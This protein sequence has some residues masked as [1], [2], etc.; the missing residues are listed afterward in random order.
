M[1]T[2][3]SI[4][5]LINKFKLS[6]LG[7]WT[8]LLTKFASVQLV[9]QALTSLGGI[10]LIRT[11]SKE[12]YAYLTIAST[13]QSTMAILVDMGV[14]ASL[15]AI[16]GKVWQ[17]QYRFGQL[18]NTA[19]Q[20]RY[21]LA[22][23]SVLVTVPILLGLLI[24]N[25]ASIYYALMLTGIVLLGLNY[26]I[27]NGVL[28]IVPKLHSLVNKIQNLELISAI[29]RFGFLGLACL[30]FVNAALTSLIT[31]I[32]GGIQYILWK[33]IASSKL[34]RTASIN[35]ED[36]RFILATM[37]SVA[38][39]SIFFCV[40]GQLT[41]FLISLFG[42]VENVAEVGALGRLAVI[43]TIINSTLATIVIPSFARCHSI[44]VLRRRY[45]QILGIFSL[46]GL[47]FVVAS[48]IYADQFLWILGSKY[49]HLRSELIIMAL[50]TSFNSLVGL[51][52]SIN[53]S[54]AWVK[55]MWVEIPTTLFFQISL[56]T[57]LDVS[58]V[59]GIVLFSL[60]SNIPL[61][62]VNAALTYQGF[63]KQEVAIQE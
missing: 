59:R 5:A 3:S 6:R 9:V 52:V 1:E 42:K 57:V 2:L 47:L 44:K 29:I 11:L 61:F 33:R 51:M 54:K 55:H 20:L 13:M 7:Y 19:I 46:L 24:Q 41:I 63:L 45:F 12:E 18:I 14:G 39:S 26:Q 34:D 22:L 32:I 62:L 38:P 36:K 30:T 21:R 4:T 49:S 31:S 15:F 40:Q 35:E 50:A 53:H 48:G 60:F 17:D 27:A 8:T 37:R 10:L 43:F 28:M 58:T 23:F 16:G 56:L 25:G